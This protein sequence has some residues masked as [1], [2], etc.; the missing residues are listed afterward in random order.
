MIVFPLRAVLVENSGPDIERITA[1]IHNL[2]E[3]PQ[4]KVVNNLED[5]KLQL[6][7]FV[8][9]VVISDY[10]FPSFTGLDVLE[11]TQQ[12]DDS[13]PFIFITGAIE[14][15]ELAAN[16]ILAGATGYILKKNLD[17]LEN[18]LKPLLKKI[19]FNLE[20]QEEIRD[21]VR[22]NKIAVNQIYN[23][24]DSLNSDNL[25]QRKNIEAIKQHIAQLN[26]SD[27]K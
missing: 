5:L 24:L 15:E 25:D 20:V 17:Q 14:D 22:R 21:R 16:T 4:V 23:Y 2:V 18:K 7:S 8:P 27:K 19:V 6:Q 12:T 9:D 1:A 3:A 10:N 13:M 26:S 11:L